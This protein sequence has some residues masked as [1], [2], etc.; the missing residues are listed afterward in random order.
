MNKRRSKKLKQVSLILIIF[1]TILAS[2]GCWNNRD[3]T[4]MAIA[5]AI[6]FDKTKDGKLKV[7]LQIVKP[8]IIKAK[9]QGNQERAVWIHS[10]IGKTAFEAIRNSLKTIDRKV[11][12]SHNQIV[13]ISEEVAKEG[14]IGIL[15]LFERNQNI[16]EL[17]EILVAKES[18][19]LTA[20][21][22]LK[23]ESELEDIP[24]IHMVNII[25]SNLKSLAKIR[26]VSVFKL[27]KVL[28]SKGRSP[29][30]G[31]IHLNKQIDNVKIKDLK[32]EGAAVFKK[33][34]LIGWLGPIETRGLLFPLNEV[35]STV[36]TLPNPMDKK[37]ELDFEILSS[38][39]EID[40]KLKNGELTFLIKI[41]TK[42][43]LVSQQGKGDLTKPKI[44]KKL[45]KEVAS[46]IKNEIRNT[47]K[48][49]Q[50]KYES[51][52]F[53]FS[54][55]VHN[56]HLDYWKEV[57]NNW[58]EVFSKTPVKIEVTWNTMSTGLIKKPT[59]PR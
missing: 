14:I 18:K 39:G 34:R 4:E 2:T 27:L 10:A 37:E 53:G 36:I 51:D 48:L 21:K 41:D 8:G 43:K 35:G 50:F 23:A 49:A 19:G 59:R 25:K 33:D 55:L 1:L 6:G 24:A 40:V 28:N 46:V 20:E 31:M 13:V 58:V 57:E 9:A 54:E 3:L 32:I 30:I 52:I 42:G 26:K 7:T 45:E 47:V 16:N 56:K 22:V 15:E 17:S 5:T 38:Q 11:V 12:F 44:V 29:V